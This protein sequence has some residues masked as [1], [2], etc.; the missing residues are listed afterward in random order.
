MV[1]LRKGKEG[2]GGEKGCERQE[3]AKGR[4]G[5]RRE[6]GKARVYDEEGAS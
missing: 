2:R 3:E 6:R 4:E 1:A 5:R